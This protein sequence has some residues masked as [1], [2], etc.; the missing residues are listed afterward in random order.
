[1]ANFHG[2]APISNILTSFF[3]RI[4]SHFPILG[5]FLGFCLEYKTSRLINTVLP[6]ESLNKIFLKWGK[7]AHFYGGAPILNILTSFFQRIFTHF[8]ILRYLSGFY[9]NFDEIPCNDESLT[10]DNSHKMPKNG[11]FLRW[12]PHFRHSYTHF[13]LV[14]NSLPVFGRLFGFL[15]EIW[16]S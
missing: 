9:S 12:G 11:Q 6:T 4:F 5:Y 14:F 2:G 16:K 3:Q 8:P 10:M 7:T 15:R 1:M 13:S